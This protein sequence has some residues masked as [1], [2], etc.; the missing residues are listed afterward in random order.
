MKADELYL[1]CKAPPCNA[2]RQKNFNSSAVFEREIYIYSKMLPAFERFQRD[3]GVSAIDSFVSY[4]KVF[5]CEMNKE[6]GIY[7]LIMEDLRQKNFEMFPKDQ[8]IALD[9]QLL[10][11]REL[12]KFHGI[13]FAMKDQRP[14]EF[15]AFKEV[16]DL[17]VRTLF[18]STI[19]EFVKKTIDRAIDALEQPEHKRIMQHFRKTYIQRID[20]LKNDEHCNEFGVMT[21]GDCWNN[22]FLFQYS[23]DNVSV[24]LESN[25]YALKWPRKKF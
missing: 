19:K 13:S 1:I 5:A 4:P 2:I 14:H 20:T 23:N 10:V 18:K 7:I 16:K 6:T 21:H 12:G 3:K 8:A 15:Q 25:S 22:N 9:H 24:K 17:F 11:M